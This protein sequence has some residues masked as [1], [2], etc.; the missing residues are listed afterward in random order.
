MTIS[1]LQAKAQV[2]EKLKFRFVDKKGRTKIGTWVN[3]VHGL[4]HIKGIPTHSSISVKS[5]LMCFKEEDFT[6][7]LIK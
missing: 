1:E 3:A 5:W 2:E 4:F 6:F 7:E